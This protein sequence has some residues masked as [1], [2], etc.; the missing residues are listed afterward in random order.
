MKEI[1]DF[2]SDDEYFADEKTGLKNHTERVIEM[3]DNRF[4][5]LF[6]AWK[7]KNYPCIRINKTELCRTEQDKATDKEPNMMYSFLRQIKHIS[8]WRN[9]MSITWIH[10]D[11]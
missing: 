7:S 10:Q 1:I 2:K 6:K 11:E 8:V 4:Q 5:I 3:L 9:I